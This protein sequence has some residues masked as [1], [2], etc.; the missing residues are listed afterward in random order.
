M[1]TGIM[2][3]A[4]ESLQDEEPCLCFPPVN[5]IRKKNKKIFSH[6]TL[7]KSQKSIHVLSL[8]RFFNLRALFSYNLQY[9][10]FCKEVL[11]AFF[12]VQNSAMMSQSTGNQ[13][14]KDS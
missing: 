11:K 12:A 2:I 5:C 13:N 10:H 4:S 14:M 1:V 8:A 3:Y 9:M 6:N 7:R